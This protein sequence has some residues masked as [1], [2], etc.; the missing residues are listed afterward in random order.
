MRALTIKQ[1]EFIALM[2]Y[3]SRPYNDGKVRLITAN[4]SVLQAYDAEHDLEAFEQALELGSYLNDVELIVFALELTRSGRIHIFQRMTKL[5]RH[6]PE[7][8]GLPIGT[9]NELEQL[10]FAEA[11]NKLGDLL[12]GVEEQ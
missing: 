4:S 11:L 6:P 3:G 10:Q 5:S 8:Y 1:L 12:E 9:I 2:W 7:K